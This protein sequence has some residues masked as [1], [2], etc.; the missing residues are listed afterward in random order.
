MLNAFEAMGKGGRVRISAAQHGA[1]FEVAIADE[2]PGI[3]A[4]LLSRIGSPFVTTKPQGSGLGL[5]LAARL[6]RAAGG[7]L[8]VENGPERGAICTVRLPARGA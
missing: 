1:R 6:A 4:E 2:G 5:F 8:K 3:P 7:A